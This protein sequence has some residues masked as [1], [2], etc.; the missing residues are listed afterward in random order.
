MRHS[1]MPAA[2]PHYFLSLNTVPPRPLGT[3]VGWR[4]GGAV[5]DDEFAAAVRWSK[6]SRR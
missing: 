2:P 1:E 6:G 4:P 3:P 5:E